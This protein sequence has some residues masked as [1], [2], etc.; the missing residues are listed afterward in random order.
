MSLSISGRWQT[1]RAPERRSTAAERW[2]LE[3]SIV[4]RSAPAACLS[5]ACLGARTRPDTPARA[6][7]ANTTRDTHAEIA[8][9]SEAP[10]PW[11]A[12][13]GER[14]NRVPLTASA[15]RAADPGAVQFDA[16]V[17][18]EVPA[19][20]WTLASPRPTLVALMRQMFHRRAAP[21]ALCDACAPAATHRKSGSQW[22]SPKNN[23]PSHR[24]CPD[25][26]L[27]PKAS[28][29]SAQ[30]R[31]SLRNTWRRTASRAVRDDLRWRRARAVSG[32]A[33]CC[34]C[35]RCM[36]SSSVNH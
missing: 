34:F 25:R 27:L 10:V 6:L 9:A 8:R 32:C 15:S 30:R 2:A 21:R 33:P 20:P 18:V 7:R 13:V 35:L 17:D 22:T 16:M 19:S 4:Y 5:P 24:G 11:L 1:P 12:G 26:V 31:N 23:L 36:C 14:F 28:T 3:R 29:R